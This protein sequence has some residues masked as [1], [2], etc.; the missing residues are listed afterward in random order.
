MERAISY[1][2]VHELQGINGSKGRRMYWTVLLKAIRIIV[3]DSRLTHICFNI[4]NVCFSIGILYTD[5]YNW[6]LCSLIIVSVFAF[7]VTLDVYVL[8]GEYMGI[9]DSD[10]LYLIDLLDSSYAE[11]LRTVEAGTTKYIGKDQNNPLRDHDGL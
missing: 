11:V 9:K 8:I 7:L 6:L 5:P 2:N 1:V 10:M 3:T 4:F